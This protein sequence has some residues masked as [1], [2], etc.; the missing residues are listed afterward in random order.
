M[1]GVAQP[2]KDPLRERVER[3]VVDGILRVEHGGELFRVAHRDERSASEAGHR[4]HA[5]RLRHL[6]ALVQHHDVEGH[7]LQRGVTAR[8]GGGSDDPYLGEGPGTFIRGTR[9]CRRELRGEQS[10]FRL[11]LRLLQHLHELAGVS[12]ALAAQGLARIPRD[13]RVARSL[14]VRQVQRVG[15]DRVVDPSQGSH[16]DEI[17]EAP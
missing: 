16:A 13:I 6:R 3:A 7:T 8:R 9:L 5:R 15:Q 10:A 14:P 12:G 4:E 2:D 11:S 1:A 17:R